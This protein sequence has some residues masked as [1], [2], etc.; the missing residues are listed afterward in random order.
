MGR[1]SKPNI[2]GNP[3]IECACGCGRTFR[4]YG[5]HSNENNK[6]HSCWRERKYIK[7]HSTKGKKSDNY[8][9]NLAQKGK[10]WS[11]ITEFKKG[12]IPWNKGTLY[13]RNEGLLKKIKQSDEYY[14][15]RQ[16]VYERDNY[17]CRIC[18]NAKE[19]IA[20][21]IIPIKTIYTTFLEQY[22][23][24]GFIELYKLSKEYEDFWN[25]NNGVTVCK[26]CH[27]QIHGFNERT[28][29][30]DIMRENSVREQ[31]HT[32]VLINAANPK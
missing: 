22:I 5:F 10:H 23:G 14:K 32:K 9:R 24:V 1:K 26:K 30:W 12:R 6:G 2:F 3:L 28:K 17:R 15:W 16:F 21:H 25:V 31:A 20:H 29:Q 4:K 7:G 18:N 27:F 11:S 13:G 8:E 19:I